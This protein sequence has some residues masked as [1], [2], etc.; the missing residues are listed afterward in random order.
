MGK[1]LPEILTGTSL[2][3]LLLL[4]FLVLG[5]A[6]IIGG[7]ILVFTLEKRSDLESRNKYIRIL[8]AKEEGR[9]SRYYLQKK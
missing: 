8:E 5:V 7:L 1:V 3:L 9:D 2:G 4:T 6:A